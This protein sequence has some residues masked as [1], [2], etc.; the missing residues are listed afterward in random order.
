MTAREPLDASRVFPPE[1]RSLAIMLQA[2]AKTYGAKPL[3]QAGERSW[4][5]A[6]ALDLAARSAGRLRAAG[7]GAGDRIALV[8]EKRPEVIEGFLRVAWLRPRPVPV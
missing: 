8:C 3:V 2:R 6:E 4:S 5:F 7:L 1:E